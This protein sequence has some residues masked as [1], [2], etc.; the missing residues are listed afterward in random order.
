[1]KISIII[2][3]SRRGKQLALCLE[4]IRKQK[5]SFEDYEV[6][7]VG[8]TFKYE[9]NQGEMLIRHIPFDV[10]S[11]QRF[12]AALM[13]NVGAKQAKGH[14]LVFL[15]CD[16]IL[17][18]EFLLNT[19]VLHKEKKILSFAL[20]KKLPKGIEIHSI[21][22][23]KKH[24][25]EKDEREEVCSFFGGDYQKLHSIWLFAYSHTLCINRE[26]FFTVG[27]FC[28]EFTD[29][30]LEDSEFAYRV[31]K[32]GIPIICD[33]KSQCYH[34]W[35]LESFDKDRANGYKINLS[36]FRSK[37]DDPILDGLELCVN[38]LEPK[39]ILRLFSCG[40]SPQALSLFLYESYVRGYQKNFWGRME[41]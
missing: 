37:Y 4:G 5:M 34:I 27:M 33:S 39:I 21:A 3:Y 20:R 10:S 31:M 12:P 15:D 23:V 14:V 19:W 17:S 24:R 1:M 29:W 30:G 16:I 25:C 35:H 36:I 13:R 11:Y 41:S 6:I 28:E 2:P 38:C 18:S 26:Q 7:V 40:I 32:S 9:W 8:E 22:E